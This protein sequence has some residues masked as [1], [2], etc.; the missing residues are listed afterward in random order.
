MVRFTSTNRINTYKNITSVAVR[1]HGWYFSCATMTKKRYTNYTKYTNYTIIQDIELVYNCGNENPISFYN[2]K[3]RS[4]PN[5]SIEKLQLK[6]DI[7]P[8]LAEL[9]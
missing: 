1:P 6:T 4:S 5:I 9:N 7:D 3:P 2:I 8:L